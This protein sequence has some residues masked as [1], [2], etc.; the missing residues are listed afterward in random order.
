MKKLLVVLLSLSVLL[1]VSCGG[2]EKA[3]RNKLEKVKEKGEI[4][5]SVSPDY[6]PMEFIDKDN[7]VVGSDIEL[8]KYIAEKLGVELKIETMDFSAALTAVDFDK[9]DIG[10]SGFGWTKE[11]EENYDLSNTYNVAQGSESTCNAILIR[12]EDKDTLK[13]LEDFECKKLAAQANSI[14]E[15]IATKQTK[16]TIE[17]VSTIDQGILELTSKKVDGITLSCVVADGY[18]KSVDGLVV[19]EAPLETDTSKIGNVVVLKKGDKELLEEINKIID[20]V[21][22]KKLYEKWYEDAVKKANEEGIDLGE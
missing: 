16:A 20:E 11:R 7:N 13:T 4:V 14:Q 22:E 18:A 5:I 21:N 17:K 8:A 1:L 12:E 9:A 3:D 6:P 15:E 10:V 2:K 19:S